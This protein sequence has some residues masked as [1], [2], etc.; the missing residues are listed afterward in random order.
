M[1][2]LFLP[3]NDDIARYNKLESEQARLLFLS[4]LF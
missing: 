1:D 4:I 2:Q 3:F